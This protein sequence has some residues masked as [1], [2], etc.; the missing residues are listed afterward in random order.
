M[1]QN[2][3]SI[4]R[5]TT[6]V[7][8]LASGTHLNLGKVISFTSKQK[9]KEQ[10]ITDITGT[11]DNLRFFKGW[12][13]SFSLERRGPSLDQYFA[14]LE[15]NYFNGLDEPAATMQETITEP[16]GSVS[17]YRYERVM[18]KYDDSGERAGDK[19][20]SQKVTFTAS[21]RVRQA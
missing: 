20:V 3:Y 19:S 4:G 10:E 5:D 7:V 14:E 16:D 8:T 15:A 9:A 2:G 11:T 13:G 1:P 18:L 21:R 12:D 6:I 17:Q